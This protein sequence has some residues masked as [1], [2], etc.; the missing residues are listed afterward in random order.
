MKSPHSGDPL[1]LLEVDFVA[2]GFEPTDEPSFKGVLVA[3]V[4]VVAAKVAKGC[5][6]LEEVIGIDQDRVGDGDGG[7]LLATSAGQAA[8]LGV[9]VG[10][11]GAAGGRRRGCRPGAR[12]RQR[13]GA[14]TPRSSA[15]R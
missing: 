6:V 3:A 13:K 5:A 14:R 12:P 9:E 10:A 11:F 2:E 8:V 1:D 15:C 4:E 7:L